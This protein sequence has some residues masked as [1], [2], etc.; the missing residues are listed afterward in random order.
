MKPLD[1]IITRFHFLLGCQR[2][3]LVTF[4]LH[5]SL[6]SIH[7]NHAHTFCL[8]SFGKYVNLYD[9]LL[10]LPA[11]ERDIPETDLVLVVILCSE[12]S[13]CK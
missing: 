2:G 3:A 12:K 9:M 1:F 5:Q 4:W 8:K 11:F 13:L 7:S 6:F 10:T